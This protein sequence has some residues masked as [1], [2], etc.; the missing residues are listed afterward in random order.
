M[1]PRSVPVRGL[2]DEPVLRRC[3]DRPARR[4]ESSATARRRRRRRRTASRSRSRVAPHAGGRRDDDVAR[5]RQPEHRRRPDRRAQL[6]GR[7]R[8][9]QRGAQRVAAARPADA[10]SGRCSSETSASVDLRA[11]HVHRQAL[12]DRRRDVGREQG[13]EALRV[14]GSR[15]RTKLREHPALRRVEARV[16]AGAGRERR[17]RRPTVGP[18]GTSRRPVPP[19]A[20]H[21]QRGEIADRRRRRGPRAGDASDV[22][23]SS[24][25]VRKASASVRHSRGTGGRRRGGVS[26][27]PRVR[28][29]C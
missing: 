4:R 22:E 27:S 18:A 8:D 11:Q 15:H 26:A 3:G 25:G 21:V 2:R 12:R 1:P 6:E 7:G 16:P 9:A 5:A 23:G 20:E 17:R 10:R 13:E 28:I 19:I 29:P 24:D 14:A